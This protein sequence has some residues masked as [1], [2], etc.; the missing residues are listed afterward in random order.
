MRR[1]KLQLCYLESILK[2]AIQLIV[3]VPVK[4]PEALKKEKEK[5]F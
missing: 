5:N 4:K 2:I 1:K 3:F